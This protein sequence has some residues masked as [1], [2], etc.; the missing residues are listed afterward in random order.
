MGGGGVVSAAE[1]KADPWGWVSPEWIKQ[2]RE[3]GWPD[4][5]PEDYCHRCGKPNKSWCAYPLD[6]WQD[7]A[8]AWSAE[9]GREGICCIDCFTTMYAENSDTRPYWMITVHR[10]EHDVTLGAAPV[11]NTPEGIVGAHRWSTLHGFCGCGDD[12]ITWEDHPA[13]VVAALTN[14]GQLDI[15]YS[16]ERE[17]LDGS[18]E[19][20]A[21]TWTRAEVEAFALRGTD[22]AVAVQRRVFYGEWEP[23]DAARV[24]EDGERRG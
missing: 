8:R 24:A 5:H 3:R 19:V 10:P 6:V 4:M 1:Q 23:M 7:G 20:V 12:T 16:V 9:T 13:H 22:N 15:E 18:R 2:Q 11:S 17:L 14:A 21:R